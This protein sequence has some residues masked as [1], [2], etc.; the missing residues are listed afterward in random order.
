[1]FQPVAGASTAGESNSSDGQ[2]AQLLK[3]AAQRGALA[4]FNGAKSHTLELSAGI[5]AR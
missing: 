3:H 2:N 1:M 4:Q 5:L